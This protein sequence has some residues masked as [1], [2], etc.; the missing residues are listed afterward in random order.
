MVIY[1]G[2]VQPPT[3]L[4]GRLISLD[5]FRGLSIAGMIL[6]NNPGSWA[7]IY[8]PLAHAEWHGWTPTDLIFPFFLFI[9]GVS[10]TF[11]FG[12][13]LDSETKS[14]LY[15]DVL[16]RSA[17]I[18][19]LGLFLSLFPYFEFDRLRYVGVL[20]RIALVYL[21]AS[22]LFL[23]LSRRALAQ[24]TGGILVGYWALMALFPVPGSGTGV[25]EPDGNFAH[26]LDRL[27]VPGRMYKGTWDPEGFAS[28]LPAVATALLGVFTGDWLRSGRDRREIAAGLFAWGWLAILAGLAWSLFFPINKHLWSSSYVLFSAGAALEVLALCYWWIDVQ[29][30]RRWA[31]PLVVFG[32]NAIAVFVASGMLSRLLIEVRVPAGGDTVPLKTWLFEH[33]FASW[34]SPV[35]ASLAFALTYVLFWWAL[36]ALLYRRR[37]FI[38]V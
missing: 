23:N 22:L 25:L 28:T 2:I 29:G 34:L 10:M 19:A 1:T 15:L 14:E 35:N 3:E 26:W 18:Y 38:K 37:I 13:R 30:H 7:H 21:V 17:I 36:M 11:S 12:K 31:Q 8:P 20:P 6:V 9:V 16:R 32:V 5:A 33:L 27:L 24:V 4:S